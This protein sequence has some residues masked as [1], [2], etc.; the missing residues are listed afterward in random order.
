MKKVLL[1]VIIAILVLGGA[2]AWALTNRKTADQVYM[3]ALERALTTQEK[4]PYGTFDLNSGDI[5]MR[6]EF[7]GDVAGESGDIRGDFDINFELDGIP[8]QTSI[9]IIG[10]EG[11]TSESYLRYKS[12]TSDDAEYGDAVE[13]YFNPVLG[14]WLK[15]DEDDT[16][17]EDSPWNLEED[18]PIGVFGALGIFF[19]LSN[20][21]DADRE[22]YLGAIEKYN[23]Y[24]VDS[25]I[26]SQ[27][28]KGI[29]TRAITV[30]VKEDAFVEFD[31]EMSER[32]SADANFE[33]SDTAF[34]DDMFGK[35][36][37]L[38]AQIYLDTEEDR[39]IGIEQVIE[40]NRTIT[41]TEFDTSFD[42]VK[43]SLLVDYDRPLSIEA[44]KDYLTEDQFDALL[45]Q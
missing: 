23:L 44:P 40:L 13:E 34:I 11:E 28:F 41:E 30:S 32:L 5:Q 38:T 24:D 29:E 45:S 36:N 6:G 14:K 33:R 43:Y 42:K 27:R 19:P 18:G 20:L 22:I 37:T 7:K 39:I 4:E 31:K 9:E 12:L 25:A 15:A 8:I 2:A 17:D 10:I 16:D 3:N 1:I 26:E 35:N 21:S